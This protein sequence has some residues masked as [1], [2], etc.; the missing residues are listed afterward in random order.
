MITLVKAL[1]L[2]ARIFLG[3]QLVL[4][5]LL[6]FGDTSLVQVHVIQGGL[7]VL[8]IWILAVI[9]LFALDKRGL[10]LFTLL[11]G[12]VI[13]WFGVAQRTFLVGSAH[14]TIRVLHLLLGVAVMGLVEPL[15]KAVLARYRSK[16]DP[17][18]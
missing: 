4:G 12:G 14:W 15:A 5:A 13:L 3:I 11:M 18:T 6:W 16:A 17:A 2:F 1:L 7:F 9:A 10:P 8:V